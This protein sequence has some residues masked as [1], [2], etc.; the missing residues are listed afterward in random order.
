[1]ALYC[2]VAL[3]VPLDQMFTYAVNGAMSG[4]GPVVGAR[5]IVPFSGQRLMGV[6]VRVHEE[7]PAE[8]FE[9]KP[10]QQVLDDVALLPDELM[11]L[12][13]WIAQY[14]VAPLGEVLRGMLPLSAEVKRHFS[15]RIAEAGRKVLYEGAAKGSSRRS[16][17]TAE[18]QN[19][20]YAVLNYLEG[21]EPAKTS[22]LRSATGANK[23]LLEGM[24]RKKWLVREAVAE[25]RD[26]R[27]LEKVAVL[28]GQG[29]GV[30]EESLGNEVSGIGYQVSSVA[31]RLPRLN[32]NQLAMMAELAAV[33]GRMRVRDLRESL[34]RA[35]VP[36]S[37]LGTLVKRGL[38]MVEE[39]AEE[40]HLG[41]VSA[42]GKKH[43]HEHDLNEAQTEALGT[44]AAAM[45][46]GG[47]RPHLLYGVTG[48][49]K[50]TVYF[51]AMR[52]ALDAGKTC[53]AAGSG[54]WVDAGDGGAA[55][56]GV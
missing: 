52:R 11:E 31:K 17:L 34:G 33:G 45:E 40:F 10:V 9:I 26:A 3:P 15:Y 19:R 22:A 55:G 27:R 18:E 2:D 14:Y 53:A 4:N 20:E 12:A 35:G 37:T 38:V 6:V 47:F 36:V 29:I 13:R 16:K 41:G 25:E 32:E 30:A 49:G 39:V 44:I 48:S 24:V 50:T 43:A 5:V 8:D 21:G 28:V 46:H 54:D 7:A 56:G 23:G 51:A 42:L 1:M